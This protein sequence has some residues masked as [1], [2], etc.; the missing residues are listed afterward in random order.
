MEK[1]D[2]ILR[3]SYKFHYLESHISIIHVYCYQDKHLPLVDLS[4]LAC[5]NVNMEKL[6]EKIMQTFLHSS[7]PRHTLSKGFNENHSLPVLTIRDKPIHSNIFHS[8]VY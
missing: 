6:A 4:P 1:V 5:I 8:I 2:L 3:L 7:I